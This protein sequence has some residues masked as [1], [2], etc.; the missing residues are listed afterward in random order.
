MLGEC[1]LIKE[2]MVPELKFTVLNKKQMDLNKEVATCYTC[3]LLSQVLSKAVR[4][5]IWLTIQNHMNVIGVAT[6]LDMK[7]VVICDGRE[8]PKPVQDKADGENI[9][10]LSTPL[11]AFELSGM[12]YE[13][14]FR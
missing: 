1:M 8:V 6:M 7:A 9:L 10:L 2:L 14:G 5:S 3:D 13:R 12:L 4:G 11:S